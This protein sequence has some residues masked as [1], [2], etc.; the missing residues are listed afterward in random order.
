LAEHYE[1]L[2]RTAL[3]EGPGRA[4]LGAALLSSKGMAAWIRG[5]RA[6]TPVP[7]RRDNASVLPTSHSD[8]VGLLAAMALACAEGG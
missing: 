3:D 2:R 4:G 1:A 7:P 5:W 8:V 6:C